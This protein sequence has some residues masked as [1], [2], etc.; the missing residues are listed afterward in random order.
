MFPWRSLRTFFDLLVVKPIVHYSF[1]HPASDGFAFSPSLNSWLYW[2]ISLFV[3]GWN[4]HYNFLRL[5]IT[6]SL[7]HLAFVVHLG[8]INSLDTLKSA[9][10]FRTSI[11]HAF[12]FSPSH[13]CVL[14][15]YYWLTCDGRKRR[16]H[17]L[18]AYLTYSKAS[19]N[20]LSPQLKKNEISLAP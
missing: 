8:F 13:S 12:A 9:L 5:V 10:R 6:F 4:M 14:L 3:V 18:M 11:Y 15:S 20:T 1:L 16:T 17:L 2:F 7:S 19:S